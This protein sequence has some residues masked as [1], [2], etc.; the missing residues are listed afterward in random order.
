MTNNYKDKIIKQ[1]MSSRGIDDFDPRDK[2][3]I[4]YFFQHI[5]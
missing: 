5:L 2:K 4:Y 3:Q 1:Y